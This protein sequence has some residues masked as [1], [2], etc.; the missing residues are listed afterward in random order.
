ML[1]RSLDLSGLEDW[2]IWSG[3]NLGTDSEELVSG[4]VGDARTDLEA[5]LVRSKRAAGWV[6]AVH[7][8]RAPA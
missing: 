4:R 3:V 7:L 1:S 2:S 5:A 6:M 8:L